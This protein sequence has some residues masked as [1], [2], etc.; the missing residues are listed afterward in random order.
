MVPPRS[1][2]KNRASRPLLAPS[3]LLPFVPRD[4]QCASLWYFSPAKCSNGNVHGSQCIA[5]WLE[6]VVV[7]LGLISAQHL[8]QLDF[9]NV[10]LT[11]EDPDGYSLREGLRQM[12]PRDVQVESAS[13]CW[14]PATRIRRS[15]LVE[16]LIALGLYDFRHE[17]PS[18][19]SDRVTTRGLKPH[20]C[21]WEE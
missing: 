21:R 12:A 17:R 7:F 3:V 18:C 20:L 16:C 10:A 2:L 19:L 14:P 4:R 8:N 1:P 6:S 9:V 15:L 13:V 11:G 5:V